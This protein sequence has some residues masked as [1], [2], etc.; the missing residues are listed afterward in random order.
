MATLTTSATNLVAAINEHE[1]QINSNNTDIASNTSS[2]S[3]N[4]S[5]ITSNDT[6]IAT[7]ATN[8]G[9][10]GDLTTSA[11]NLVAAINEHETQINSNNSGIT[12][13]TQASQP[14]LQI[15]STNSSAISTINSTTLANFDSGARVVDDGNSVALGTGAMDTNSSCASCVAIGFNALTN[16]N[17]SSSGNVAIGRDAL[18]SLKTWTSKF[19]CWNLLR[20]WK[21]L[22]VAGMLISGEYAG[23]N[24]GW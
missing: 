22:L 13:N 20:L 1:T 18:Y 5:N 21:S 4:A 19:C 3:T 17:L 23:Y 2:I 14:M 9:T 8:I 24:P 10:V 6:D 12:S 15:I 16:Q 11:T 7:N